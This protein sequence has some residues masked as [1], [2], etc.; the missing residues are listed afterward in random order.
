MKNIKIFKV[1]ATY[2]DFGQYSRFEERIAD[3]LF[4]VYATSDEED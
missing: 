3:D 4:D 2:A 1:S